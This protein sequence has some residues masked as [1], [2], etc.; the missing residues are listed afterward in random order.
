MPYPKTVAIRDA[1]RKLAEEVQARA[2]AKPLEE[3]VRSAGAKELAKFVKRLGQDRVT[4][5]L[6]KK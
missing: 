4:A 2:A 1:R 6:A 5:I 3:R